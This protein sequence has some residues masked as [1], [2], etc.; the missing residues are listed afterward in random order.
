MMTLLKWKKHLIFFSCSVV[1][2][3]M[4]LHAQ[5]T[6]ECTLCSTSYLVIQ[7]IKKHRT[8]I[9]SVTI[10]DNKCVEHALKI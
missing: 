4:K 5:Y 1:I 6:L 10:S 7:L 9:E 3:D 8:A 2:M